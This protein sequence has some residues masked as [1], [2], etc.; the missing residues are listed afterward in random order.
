MKSKQWLTATFIRPACAGLFLL[1]HG[2][3]EAQVVVEPPPPARCNGVCSAPHDYFTQVVTTTP[4]NETINTGQSGNYQEYSLGPHSVLATDGQG[5]FFAVLEGV[6]LPSN[7]P[8]VV[9]RGVAEAQANLTFGTLQASA[10]STIL[11]GTLGGQIGFG[12]GATARFG[13]TLFF[14]NPGGGLRTIDFPI[15]IHGEI[16]GVIGSGAPGASFQLHI[17]SRDFRYLDFH[18]FDFYAGAPVSLV[19][20]W[21]S[22]LFTQII[23]EHVTLQ[24]SFSGPEAYVPIFA[25]LSVHGQFGLA[26]FFDTVAFSF[27]SLPDGVSFT[28]ASGGFLTGP[29]AV[30]GP[31]VGAGLPGLILAGG[32]LL[33]WWRRRRS[34]SA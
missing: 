3:C 16:D 32:G 1:A 24:F 21:S 13:D 31:I 14:T 25:E 11:V 9:S 23:D 20:D 15:H 19:R 29:A 2:V 17:G 10:G 27:P 22:T 18:P 34:A 28:S 5:T 7:F 33:G 6:P 30:P 12:A 8:L 4:L 26:H